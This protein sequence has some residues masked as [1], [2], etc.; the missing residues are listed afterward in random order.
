MTKS[1][2]RS[3]FLL[4]DGRPADDLSMD[5]RVNAQYELTLPAQHL[6]NLDTLLR[7]RAPQKFKLLPGHEEVR[8]FLMDMKR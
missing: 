6:N 3:D 5:E 2:E 1:S 7:S 4:L 8:F